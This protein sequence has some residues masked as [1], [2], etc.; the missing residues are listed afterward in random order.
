MRRLF[1]ALPASAA[2][3]AA[4]CSSAPDQSAPEPLAGSWELEKDAS[5]LAFVTIKAGQVVEA[6]SFGDLSGTVA[7][8]GMASFAIDLASV[9]TNVEVRDQRMRD[10]LFQVA[11]FPQAK[12]SAQIDPASLSGL[13]LGEQTIVPVTA[14][15]DLHGEKT[16]IETRLA[17]TRIAPD[18]VE[19]ETTSPIILDAASY[20]LGDGLAQLQE[21]AG[22][23]AITAQVPVTFSLVFDKIMT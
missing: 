2:L 1:L 15:L 3:L 6:H 16:P 19:V 11:D 8:D 20:A 22:L 18:K 23:P 13:G 9:N 7:E 5:R 4:A 10:I 21:L 12:V 17:V 14:T